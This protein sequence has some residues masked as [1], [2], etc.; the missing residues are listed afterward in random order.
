MNHVA[1]IFPMRKTYTNAKIV[2]MNL[3]QEIKLKCEFCDKSFTRK[4]NLN[5]EEDGNNEDEDQQDEEEAGSSSDEQ[6]ESDA[7]DQN[8][9]IT[10]PRRTKKAKRSVD[11]PKKQKKSTAK[12]NLSHLLGKRKSATA[13]SERIS[14]VTQE[15][16]GSGH[17]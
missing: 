17:R 12:K 7:E 15:E 5:E 8:K 4:D 16:T 9:E 3:Q 6:N 2:T 14:R 11:P 13:A 10:P 1:T